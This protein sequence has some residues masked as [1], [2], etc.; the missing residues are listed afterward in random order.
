[1]VNIITRQDFEGLEVGG[2]YGTSYAGGLDTWQGKI[3]GGYGNLE[4]DGFNVLVSLEAYTRERL[5]QDERD[6]TKSGIYSGPGGRWNGWSAKGA[7]FLINGASAPFVDAQGNCP[8]GMVLTASAP[9]DGLA[10]DTCAINLAPYTTL[11]PSTD[12]YQAYV[13][14]T[15]RVAPGVEAFGE[16]LY[17]HIEGTS[18][19]GSSPYFTLEAGRFALNA[20]TGLAEPVSNLLAASNPYNPYGTA[21][22]I[23][24]TFFDLGQSLK[25]NTS[26]AYRALGGLRGTGERFDWEVAVFASASRERERVAAGFANRWTLADALNSGALN[27]WEPGATS[28]AVLDGIRLSTLRPADSSLYGADLQ[29]LGRTVRAAGRSHRLCGGDRVPARVA[30]VPQSGRDRR[31]PAGSAGHRGPWTASATWARSTLRPISRSCRTWTSRS[32]GRGDYYS[33]FGEAFSPKVGV[34]W[35]AHEGGAGA[36]LGLARLPGAVAV[37]EL[38]LDQHLL[39]VGRRSL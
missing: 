33:D 2:S 17:S 30:R 7:R 8:Q 13:H 25:T 27:L 5:D 14:A 35:R 1:M 39:W 11:I 6:L 38:G 22:P 34:R 19:F 20:Q 36:G 18:I 16:L 10:G 31:R 21:V 12:R 9:I 15:A 23:E 32:P 37:G 26:Q 24:Y 28:Q 3:V 29:N 4:D